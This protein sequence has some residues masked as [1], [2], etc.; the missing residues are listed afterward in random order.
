M[1]RRAAVD[2]AALELSSSSTTSAVAIGSCT[3]SSSSEVAS[4]HDGSHEVV[5]GGEILEALNR[6]L[7]LTKPLLRNVDVVDLRFVLASME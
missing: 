5:E 7:G 6:F 3:T 2:A 4:F 1:F